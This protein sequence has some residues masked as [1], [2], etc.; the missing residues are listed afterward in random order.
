LHDNFDE[1]FSVSLSIAIYTSAYS[2]SLEGEGWDEGG[3]NVRF[4]SPLPSPLQQEREPKLNLYS[5]RL[6]Q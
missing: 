6:F 4:Y 1:K 3:Y 2:F 5:H